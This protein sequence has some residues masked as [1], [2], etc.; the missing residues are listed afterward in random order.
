M[1]AVRFPEDAGLIEV[2]RSLGVRPE[3]LLGHGGEAWVYALDGERVVRVLHEGHDASIIHARQVLVEELASDGTP[4]AL[5]EVLDAG[6][7]SGRAFAVERRLPGVPIS[8]QLV[9]LDG[10]DRDLLVE[11]HLDAAAQLCSLHLEPRGW[12]GELIGEHPVRSASWHGFLRER[13]ARSLQ[14]APAAFRGVDPD[15]LADALPDSAG[16]AFVHLDVFAGNMLASGTAITAVLDIGVTSACGD[17]RLDPLAA[18]VYLASPEITPAAT[19]RDVD[20]AM[21]WLRAAGLADCFEP[22]QRWL[23]AYWSWAIDDIATHEW[24]RAVLLADA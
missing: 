16:A 2:L 22:A 13:V 1:Q 3:D 14:G 6:Q 11:H 19:G 17:A 23:A 9:R 18:A 20:V 4:F 24:C 12:F 5:P 10:G 15:A 7:V 21:S 8:E